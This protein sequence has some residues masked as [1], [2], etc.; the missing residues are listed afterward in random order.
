MFAPFK[1]MLLGMLLVSFCMV[2]GCSSASNPTLDPEKDKPV[3]D[4]VPEPTSRPK[5]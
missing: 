1:S 2:V 3:M 4:G 5:R